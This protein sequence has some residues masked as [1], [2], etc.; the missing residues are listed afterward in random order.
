[1]IG[2]RTRNIVRVVFEV[3]GLFKKYRVRWKQACE[4]IVLVIQSAS[5]QVKNNNNKQAEKEYYGDKD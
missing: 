2:R 4:S 1:M 5:N 3:N